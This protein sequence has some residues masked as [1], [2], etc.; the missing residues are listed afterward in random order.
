[1]SFFNGCQSNQADLPRDLPPLGN[2]DWHF[3]SREVLKAFD[4]LNYRQKAERMLIVH[5]EMNEF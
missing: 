2:S 4:R 1:M 3:L 5:P